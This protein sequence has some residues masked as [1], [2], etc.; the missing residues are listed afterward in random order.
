M[1]MQYTTPCRPRHPG[2]A[3]QDH[4][5]HSADSKERPTS[6]LLKMTKYPSTKETRMPK[7]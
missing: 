2:I 7:L 4:F 6:N 1:E 3:K 5:E